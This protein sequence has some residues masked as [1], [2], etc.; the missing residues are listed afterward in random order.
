MKTR[1]A[2][3]WMLGCIGF[4]LLAATSVNRPSLDGRGNLKVI[5]FLDPECPV[6]N[7][8]MREIKS[9]HSDYSKKGVAFEAVFPVPTVK[10][11]DIKRFLSKYQAAMPGYQDAGLQKVKRYQAT[12][13]PEAVLVNANGE[14]LYRGAIDNWYY[15]LGKNR[16]KATELYLRNAIEAVLNGEMVLVSRTDAIGCV[17]N[18]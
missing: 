15:A 13:M 7:A 12:V 4:G 10:R 3:I 8:Y 9:I 6:S 5:F 11:E 16:A 2:I 17:I 1:S 18:Q 14:I